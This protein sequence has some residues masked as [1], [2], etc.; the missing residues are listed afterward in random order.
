MSTIILAFFFY[1]LFNYM[2]FKDT[3]IL[4]NDQIVELTQAYFFVKD[5]T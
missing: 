5:I 3:L 2:S 1:F 4:C